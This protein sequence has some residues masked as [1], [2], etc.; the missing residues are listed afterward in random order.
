MVND[1]WITSHAGPVEILILNTTSL[2]AVNL[3]FFEDF[4]YLDL[5][6]TEFI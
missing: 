1:K 2:K 6:S 5:L 4:D 3:R